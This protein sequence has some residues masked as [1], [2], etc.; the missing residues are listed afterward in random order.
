MGIYKW[1]TLNRF[2]SADTIVP[3]FLNPQSLNRYSYVNNN[4]LNYTDP[5]GHFA[6]DLGLGGRILIP[7]V[8]AVYVASSNPTLLDQATEALTDV[9]TAAGDALEDAFEN[10]SEAF[11]HLFSSLAGATGGDPFDP[12][13]YKNY[14]DSG[15]RRIEPN[16]NVR[17]A[18]NVLDDPAYGPNSFRCTECAS[19]V[20]KAFT[21]AG[22]QADVLQI[23]FHKA[24]AIE[25]MHNG[26]LVRIA[27][28]SSSQLGAPMH[29][30]TVVDGYAYDA[31]TGSQGMRVD[32]YWQAYF[33]EFDKGT[34]GIAIR[35]IGGG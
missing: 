20:S 18:L 4:A 31:L 24:R 33:A 3:D 13:N 14:S 23:E 30:V 16:V 12:N 26:E 5:T 35:L 15:A 22:Y 29:Q 2:V 28:Y 25:V 10:G 27:D 19:Q 8:G 32:L 21:E 9:F 34:F 17:N 11:Q 7:I 1:S 6:E